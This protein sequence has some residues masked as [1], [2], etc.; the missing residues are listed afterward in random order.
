MRNPK[1]KRRVKVAAE[2]GVTEIA[3]LIEWHS[4]SFLAFIFTTELERLIAPHKKASQSNCLRLFFLV[5]RTYTNLDG[6][7]TSTRRRSL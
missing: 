1:T 6:H 7:C 5:K 2:R 4:L 3:A